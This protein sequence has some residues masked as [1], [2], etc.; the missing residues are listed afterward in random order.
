MCLPSRAAV[1][2]LY[3]RN[4]PLMAALSTSVLYGWFLARVTRR[5]SNVDVPECSN[6]LM[7]V[8]EPL[9]AIGF[10]HDPIKLSGNNYVMR[11]RCSQVRG[12]RRR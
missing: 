11:D 9:G 8:A 5:V 7:E 4:Q 3:S 1:G 10:P 6:S 12:R 2:Y